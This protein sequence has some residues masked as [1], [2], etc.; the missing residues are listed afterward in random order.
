MT[1]LFDEPAPQSRLGPVFL[2]SFDS[3]CPACGWEIEAGDKIRADGRGGFIHADEECE[4][5]S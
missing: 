3:E 2:A 1:D 5:D 4:K